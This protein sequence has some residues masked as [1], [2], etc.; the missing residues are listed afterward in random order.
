M[1]LK[2]FSFA[3]LPSLR[4]CAS[5]AADAAEAALAIEAC[6]LVVDLVGVVVPE[7]GALEVAASVFAI[8]VLESF[9]GMFTAGF[10]PPMFKDIVTGAGASAGDLSCFSFRGLSC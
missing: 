4:S 5:F 1:K 7:A 8:A 9:A 10:V 6:V 2:P 3:P